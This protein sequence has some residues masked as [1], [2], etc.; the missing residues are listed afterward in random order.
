[1]LTI[2]WGKN[3]TFRRAILIR[4]SIFEK[5]APLLEGTPDANKFMNEMLGVVRDAAEQ[6]KIVLH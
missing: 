2:F 5:V 6:H 3:A 4:S 1:M